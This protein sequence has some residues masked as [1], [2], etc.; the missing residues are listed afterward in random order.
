MASS[1]NN[2][3]SSSTGLENLGMLILP[4][5]NHIVDP[6][7]EILFVVLLGDED[8]AA[9]VSRL[10]DLQSHLAQLDPNDVC[11]Y[12]F[13][14]YILIIYLSF[15]LQHTSEQE[16]EQEINTLS[17]IVS[18]DIFKIYLTFYLNYCGLIRIISHTNL[19]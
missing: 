10:H 16:L 5:A 4:V 13:I 18:G 12:I 9:C 1:S 11:S 19:M 8:L 2:N 17:S 14:N 3:S 7:F 6:D 15:N